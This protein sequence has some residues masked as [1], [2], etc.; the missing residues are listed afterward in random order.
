M[1]N[2]DALHLWDECKSTMPSQSVQ[3]TMSAF[4]LCSKADSN[5]IHRAECSTNVQAHK[6]CR[7]LLADCFGYCFS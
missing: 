5:G 1:P 6:E 7:Q 2:L 3:I 4:E